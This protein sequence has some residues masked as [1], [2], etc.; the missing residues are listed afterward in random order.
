MWIALEANADDSDLISLGRQLEET[1][2][3]IRTM[4]DPASPDHHIEQIESMLAGVAPVQEA[5]MATP[6]RTVA[7]LGVKA[8]HAA[9]VMSRFW[10]API[11]QIDLE[12]RAIR[13][14]IEAICAMANM[15]L[16]PHDRIR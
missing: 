14:L 2:A 1:M 15:P 5:I 16:T 4:Y 13:L 3:K 8:R 9:Y 10:E 6:A 12:D 7:G 11:D